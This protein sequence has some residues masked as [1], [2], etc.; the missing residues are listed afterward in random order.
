MTDRPAEREITIRGGSTNDRAAL[1]D[2]LAAATVLTL[3]FGLAQ[4]P[5]EMPPAGALAAVVVLGIGSTGLALIKHGINV[6]AIAPSVFRS[7]LTS[8]IFADTEAGA[9]ARARNLSR[10][11]LGR[12]GEPDDMVGPTLFLLSPASDFMTGQVV[13]VDGGLT[14]T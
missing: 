7:A 12:L 4:V 3:P 1:Y 8:W 6:N 13:Y 5:S 14:A 9:A 10:N 11:L 2:E